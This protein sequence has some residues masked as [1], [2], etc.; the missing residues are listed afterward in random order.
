MLPS[1]V[2]YSELDYEGDCS[3]MSWHMFKGKHGEKVTEFIGSNGLI[4]NVIAL[5][6]NFLR[7]N[8]K[9]H[10]VFL[11]CLEVPLVY[12]VID[13]FNFLRIFIFVF[14]LL[15]DIW[16]RIIFSPLEF[17]LVCGSL[18]ILSSLIFHC[19]YNVVPISLNGL[20]NSAGI[21]VVGLLLVSRHMFC[22]HDW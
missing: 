6:V 11:L 9:Y 5:S 2:I 1:V 3:M 16:F 4:E 10:I 15:I 19:K 20:Y 13:S 17:V 22:A 8:S 21:T 12:R 7:E 18:Y 14:A